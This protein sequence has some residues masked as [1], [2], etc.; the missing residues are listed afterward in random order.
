MELQNEAES[1]KREAFFKTDK[2]LV[3]TYQTQ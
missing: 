1:K 2:N 3:E